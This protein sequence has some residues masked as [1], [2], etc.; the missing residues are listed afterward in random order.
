M[1]EGF[2]KQAQNLS[3]DLSS[4][5]HVEEAKFCHDSVVIWEEEK[6][7]FIDFAS[8]RVCY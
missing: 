3:L 6:L 5:L 8:K 4:I 7:D 2:D 1:V